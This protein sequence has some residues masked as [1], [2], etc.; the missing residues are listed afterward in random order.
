MFSYRPVVLE[1]PHF[2]SLRN[3]E[4]E[5][6]I[7]R[8]DNGESW[9]EHT[10]SDIDNAENLYISNE[11]LNNFDSF[12]SDR[13][14]RITTNK[15]PQFFAVVSRTRQE[16]HAI[17]PEGDTVSS[18]SVPQVQA[19]FPPHALTKKIRVGLQAQ[20]IDLQSAAKLI[21]Q[22]VAVS[23]V[24]TIEPRR[25]KFH[26]AITLSIPAPLANLPGMVKTTYS[27]NTPTLRLLC[28]ITGGQ[29]RAVWEDVTGSTPLAFVKN[30]VSF[31]T[32]VSARFWLMDCRN[33]NDAI[34][35]ATD[36]Y[37]HITQV[38]F[39]VK[40]VVFAK[41]ISAQE[42]KLSVF[43][44]TDD[45]EDKTLENKSAFI[46]VAKSRDVEI[47]ENQTIYLEFQGNI[48]PVFKS[49][50]QLSFKFE[51]FRENR[52]S[53]LVHLR[54]QQDAF[55]CINFMKS[56]KANADEEP[57]QPV[58]SLKISVNDNDICP[59]SKPTELNVNGLQQTEH[60]INEEP[61]SYEKYNFKLSEIAPMLNDDW[62]SLA[63]QLRVSQSDIDMIN[64]EYD[65]NN[66]ALVMLRLWYNQNST[67]EAD[68][69][70]IGNS[71]LNAL[72]AVNR[73]DILDNI[74]PQS[75]KTDVKMNALD[76]DVALDELTNFLNQN[77]EV[78]E[79]KIISTNMKENE[80][81]GLKEV[82]EEPCCKV[83]V[84]NKTPSP[85]K[86]IKSSMY[87]N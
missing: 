80:S 32:T 77:V 56:P 42:A 4:R 6:V 33:I 69:G 74:I 17:G 55:G 76:G 49:G 27:G 10:N 31:T 51:P 71:M 20:P 30:T 52:L 39:M 3:K 25:R 18:Q 47:L 41:R 24:V 19:I 45:K 78:E 83:D 35:M 73:Y 65:I 44:M 53:F 26:K 82:V 58:C 67:N 16:V 68:I 72:K 34:R 59:V 87:S 40:F 8:S 85:E 38:P 57:Q 79:K 43:C 63:K 75:D 86:Q 29:N 12:P 13:I 5:I 64:N 36:L 7:L 62:I 61:I 37:T 22:S 50:E 2:G 28:S 54:D 9:R 60:E 14:I 84:R 15:F 1:I 48:V 11:M 23:P 66:K 46:E 21:G 70:N 81:N